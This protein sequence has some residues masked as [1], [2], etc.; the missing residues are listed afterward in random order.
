MV[1]ILLSALNLQVDLLAVDRNVTGAVNAD[2]DLPFADLQDAD[3]NVVR[4]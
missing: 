2:F 1:A 3:L 4:D